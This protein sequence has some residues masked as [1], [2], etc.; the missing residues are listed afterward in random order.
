MI[1]Y[2]LYQALEILKWLVLARVLMSWFV[3]PVS[4]NPIVHLVRRITDPILRPLSEM[5][6]PLGGIDISPLLAFF[7]IYL[8]QQVI[9]RMA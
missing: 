7:A 5:I 6:P 1:W 4:D 8:F 9:L 2:I 3:S